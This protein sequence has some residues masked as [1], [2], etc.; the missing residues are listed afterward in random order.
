M[1]QC[2][3]C[4]EVKPVEQFWSWRLQCAV[5]RCLD[6]REQNGVNKALHRLRK[7]GLDPG[8]EGTLPMDIA[9]REIP[10]L[11]IPH[12]YTCINCAHQKYERM[13]QLRADTLRKAGW[14]PTCP[15]CGG[16]QTL[17]EDVSGPGSMLG[18]RTAVSTW[19]AYEE[20]AA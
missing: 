13:T 19:N 10:P 18:A 7:Q 17:E 5:T 16:F 9:P 2:V 12:V 14:I 4:Q 3:R 1:Q 6:C 20:T 15:H 11:L 8:G